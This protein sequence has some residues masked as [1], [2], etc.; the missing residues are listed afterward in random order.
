MFGASQT[1]KLHR[2]P[3]LKDNISKIAQ[4]YFGAIAV[5]CE[6]SC[7]MDLQLHVGASA[8]K[9]DAPVVGEMGV[10]SIDFRANGD[11]TEVYSSN[12]QTNFTLLQSISG[13]L[14]GSTFSDYGFRGDLKN[15]GFMLIEKNASSPA[16]WAN[17]SLWYVGNQ[18]DAIEKYL[19]VP[20]D[21]VGCDMANHTDFVNMYCWD[22]SYNSV[23]YQVDKNSKT[24]ISFFD[25]WGYV[26]DSTYDYAAEILYSQDY[27]I[28]ETVV[29][30]K[31]LKADTSVR[32]FM[33]FYVYTGSDFKKV[34][35]SGS[36]L[37]TL[38]A[39]TSFGLFGRM[40]VGAQ[41]LV[42][43]SS[44]NSNNSGRGFLVVDIS[45]PA[46][47]SLSRYSIVNPV[48]VLGIIGSKV[49]LSLDGDTYYKTY[50]TA[51]GLQDTTIVVGDQSG[52]V[53]G[54]SIFVAGSSTSFKKCDVNSSCSTLVS[55]FSTSLIL[56]YKSD[57]FQR[58]KIYF[59]DQAPNEADRV[60]QSVVV[61]TG[62]IVTET[63]LTNLIKSK[64]IAM[65]SVGGVQQYDDYLTVQYYDV[66]PRYLVLDATNLSVKDEFVSF[67]SGN[68]NF[69]FKNHKYLSPLFKG[70]NH[71]RSNFSCS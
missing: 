48:R 5:K 50:S 24:F 60:I 8:S 59:I 28:T 6:A 37:T 61:T 15:N 9:G 30:Y 47:P 58:Q 40:T 1:E 42:L 70:W 35:I 27:N 46:T 31:V 33:D 39:D 68:A 36:D 45:N 71:V 23:R 55:D 22:S 63:A 3:I 38:K 19:D 25:K 34:A 17:R 57:V 4:L 13:T 7:S 62:A 44:Y 43:L 56:T 21:V 16:D 18:A 29:V 41:E 10:V 53:F 52:Q 11:V 20:A 12:D 67:C 49:V 26:A 65:G 32:E 66:G 64:S 69:A 14:L 54:N 51:S 2:R